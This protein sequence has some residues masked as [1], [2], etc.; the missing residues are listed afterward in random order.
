MLKSVGFLKATS[1]DNQDE[2]MIGV[3]PNVHLHQSTVSS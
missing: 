2:A 1:E 3:Q